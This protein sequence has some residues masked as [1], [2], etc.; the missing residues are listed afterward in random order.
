MITQSFISQPSLQLFDW[1]WQGHKIT[2]TVAGEGQPLLLIHG[3]GACLGHWRKNIPVLANNGYQVYALDLLGFGAS[4][5]PNLDYSLELWQELI[6]D[7]WSTHIQL[8][9]IFIGN[10]IGG[11]LS[12]MLITQQPE[13]AAGGVLINCAGGLNHRP[14]EL[15]LPLRLIMG[16]F[17]KLV[18]SPYLGKFIFNNIRQKNR[19]R[20]TLYQVYRDKTAVTEE[21]VE[22]LYTPAC[23]AGAQ[24]VFASIINAPAGPKPEELLPHLRLP[25][26]VLWGEDDPWTPI[27]GAKIYQDLALKNEAVKFY[28]IPQ[29]GHCPHDE[30]PEVVNQYILNWLGEVLK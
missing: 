27:K 23:E 22:M 4:A 2:Y 26:L 20:K 24:A 5:K 18:S 9:T 17:A 11:L 21:L 16:T 10:S 6:T 14:E 8:P 30:K 1:T 28:P 25:L 3:F 15:N 19:I 12:L 13:I 7:F 29:A